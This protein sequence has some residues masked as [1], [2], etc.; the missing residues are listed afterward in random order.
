MKQVFSPHIA[1]IDTD[2]LE[3][4]STI[5][6]DDDVDVVTFDNHEQLNTH[7][8]Q[9][10]ASNFPL[11]PDIGEWCKKGFYQY[12]EKIAKCL[13]PHTRMHFALIETPALWFVL[14]P[15]EGIREWSSYASLEFLNMPLG[16]PVLDE[17]TV[18]YLI[19]QGQGHR[20]PNDEFGHFGWTTEI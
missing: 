7:V 11:L 1:L 12:G 14:T 19:D 9:Q 18:Y 13:Q 10:S 2:I 3:H 5:Y 17:G 16:T 15:G 4:P 8:S 6:T 20:K